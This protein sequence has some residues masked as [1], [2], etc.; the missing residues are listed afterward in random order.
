MRVRASRTVTYR[1][2]SGRPVKVMRGQE[3]DL[4]PRLINAMPGVWEPVTRERE[5][6]T[7]VPGPGELERRG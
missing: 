3:V 7:T 4:P 1:G 6:R 5:R 2:P